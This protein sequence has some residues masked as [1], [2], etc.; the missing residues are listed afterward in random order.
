[1]GVKASRPVRAPKRVTTAALLVAGVWAT[2]GRLETARAGDAS[3]RPPG[4]T[5][6]GENPAQ[7]PVAPEAVA[8]E[9]NAAVIAPRPLPARPHRSPTEVT[10]RV[11]WAARRLVARAEAT[12][13]GGARLWSDVA[14]LGQAMAEAQLRRG[15]AEAV[16]TLALGAGATTPAAIL[17]EEGH[18]RATLERATAHFVVTETTYADDGSVAL[19]AYLPLEDGPAQLGALWLALWRRQPA[20]VAPLAPAGEGAFPSAAPDG[21][22]PAGDARPPTGFVVHACGLGFRPAMWPRIFDGRGRELY[23]PATLRPDVLAARGVAPLHVTLQAATRDPRL[24]ERP[25]QVRAVDLRTPGSS[26]VVLA[27]EDVAVLRANRH[28]LRDGS[29]VFLV[30]P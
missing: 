20:S 24:G 7:K 4:R 6:S 8:L 5:Q 22:R 16:T 18:W 25:T 19:Q 11:D 14:E 9:P 17:H 13:P 15:L 23:G 26:D 28:L 1:M 10:V 29:V 30:D 27:D 2:A 21:P 3:A 12:P